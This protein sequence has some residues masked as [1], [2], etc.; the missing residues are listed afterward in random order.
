MKIKIDS[1]HIEF[2]KEI[3]A[4]LLFKLGFKPKV[5]KFIDEYTFM[6]GYG[7]CESI[8]YFEYNLPHKYLPKRY[9]LRNKKIKL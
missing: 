9:L 5:T 8:G 4:I 3:I 6:Y 7:K 2:F 1:K